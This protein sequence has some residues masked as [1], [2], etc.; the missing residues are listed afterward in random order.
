MNQ[1]TRVSMRPQMQ[2][3]NFIRAIILVLSSAAIY[4]YLLYSVPGL[5]ELFQGFGAELPTATRWLLDYY[6][7]AAILLIGSII[8][9]VALIYSKMTENYPLL[10]HLDSA[11][12]WYFGVSAASIVFTIIAIYLPIFRLGAAV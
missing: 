8:L 6:P 1:D 11:S 9:L 12:S 4:A 7:A 2:K 5:Q 10:H 3:V